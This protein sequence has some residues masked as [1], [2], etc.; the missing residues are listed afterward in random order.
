MLGLSAI[1]LE[2]LADTSASVMHSY[3]TPIVGTM[4]VLAS[5]VCVFFIVNSGFHYLTSSGKPERLEHAK[6]VLRNALIGLIIVVAA[7]TL[8]AVLS[9]AYGSPG[10]SVNQQLPVLSAIKPQPVSN[11]LVDVL[12]KA[13]TGLLNNIIQSAA[14]PFLK[15][16][17]F[18]TTATP[19]MAANSSVFNLWLVIVGIADA[20]FVLVVALLGFHVMSYATFG[21]DELE[22]KHL[23]PQ[24]GL[25]FV[26]VNSS[27]FLIDGLISLSNA[28]IRA[29]DVGFGNVT[30]WS[31]LTKI[32]D[33]ASGLGLATLLI[34]VAFLVFAVILL[35]YYVGRIVTLYVGAVLSPLALLLW[36]I[37]SFRD[38][39]ISAA[40]VYLT[41]IFVLFIH[42]VILQLAASLFSGMAAGS[43]TQT[44]DTLMALVVGLATLIALLKTQGVL[45]QLSYVSV[46]PKTARKLGSQFINGVSYFGGKDR[47]NSP[48]T[49]TRHSQTNNSISTIP[50]GN[51]NATSNFSAP[52]GNG[53]QQKAGSKAQANTAKIT[54]KTTKL[55]RA[56]KS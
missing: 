30:V 31:V 46:G 2:W 15:A 37:P 14:Q 47:P 55:K 22:F 6:L 26:L 19:L 40:K 45:T 7:G 54:T 4:V 53:R 8:T 28:M 49:S 23:L 20:L 25:V 32:V 24:L 34:M 27:L 5:L 38:F 51:K 36:L 16:L 42:V 11:G 39:S 1:H 21:L 41:T 43:P 9:H 17:A 44:P 18:F 52:S 3:I 10:G 50:K 12:I 33:Q 35:V 13:I 29:L 48:Q 56:E